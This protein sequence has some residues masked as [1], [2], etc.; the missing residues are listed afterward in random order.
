VRRRHAALFQVGILLRD[1]S[2]LADLMRAPDEGSREMLRQALRR[3]S[4][5]LEKTPLGS[6]PLDDL[7]AALSP[8]R[9]AS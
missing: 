2:G 9:P 4:F 6:R 8:D 7:V 3:R 1:Q 5:G